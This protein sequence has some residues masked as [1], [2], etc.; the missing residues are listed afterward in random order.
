MR[1]VRGEM[2]WMGGMGRMGM[3]RRG[4]RTLW[5][6]LDWVLG[7]LGGHTCMWGCKSSD[8]CL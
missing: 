1:Y 5:N 4:G 2:I 3:D 8:T 7:G 6:S